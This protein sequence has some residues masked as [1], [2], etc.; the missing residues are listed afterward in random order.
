MDGEGGMCVEEEEG[1]GSGQEA[2]IVRCY[3]S[4]L[5]S[6]FRLIPSPNEVTHTL[7]KGALG[8]R[9]GTYF[10]GSSPR[11][12]RGEISRI[13]SGMTKFYNKLHPN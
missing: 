5:K 8:R 7:A 4:V 9:C 3:F 11:R 12:V 1:V 6:Y 2:C 13:F 10:S